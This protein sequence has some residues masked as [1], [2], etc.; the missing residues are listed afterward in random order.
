MGAWGHGSFENDDACD[1]VYTLEE[2]G[3]GAVT[4]T[5]ETF[6]DEADDYLEAPTC[7]EIL[8]AGEVVAALRGKSGGGLTEEVQKW[9]EGKAIPPEDLVMRIRSAVERVKSDS[10]LKELW[11]ESEDFDRWKST[12]DD[13]ISRLS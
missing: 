1:W 10:E 4:Q 9:V 5:L 7:S 6:D 8:A 12:V 2:S 13:L 11:E 3:I